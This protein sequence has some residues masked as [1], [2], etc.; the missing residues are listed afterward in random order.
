MEYTMKKIAIVALMALSTAAIAGDHYAPKVSVYSSTYH[1][2]VY[3]SGSGSLTGA[4]DS[5]DDVQYITCTTAKYSYDGTTQN[6]GFCVATDKDW[7][8]ASCYTEDT[9]QIAIIHSIGAQ[10]EFG[11]SAIDGMCTQV[12]AANGSQYL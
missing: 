12:W 10:S 6:Y 1:H 11:F 3:G 2:V 7:N 8:S 4:S 5:P 9:E